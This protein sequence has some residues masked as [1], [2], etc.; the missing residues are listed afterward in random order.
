ME[1]KLDKR[2]PLEKLEEEIGYV[3]KD[4]NLLKRALTHTSFAN[5]QKI[6]KIG[7]YER[8]EFLGD[9]VLELISSEFLYLKFSNMEEGKLTRKRA[10]LVCEMALADSAKMLSLGQYIFLGKGEQAEG[11]KTSI[12][13]DVMEAII[14]AIYL[15]GGLEEAKK[16]VH[17]YV[18]N[19]AEHKQMFYDAKTTLQELVQQKKLGAIEYSVLGETGPEHQKEFECAVAINDKIVGKGKG[20]TKK[21]AE[22]KAAYETLLL[23]KK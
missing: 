5:E 19:D 20:K 2:M 8:I 21:E 10:A 1:Q 12:V 4:K 16:F 7:H 9:A 11:V 3:F 17:K 13:A 15:D 18:L 23:L 6:N 22:Q 14:G